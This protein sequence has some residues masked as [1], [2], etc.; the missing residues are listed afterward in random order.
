[1][2]FFRKTIWNSR[3]CPLS[4]LNKVSKWRHCI[5][6]VTAVVK[7]SKT[8]GDVLA[9]LL[10]TTKEADPTNITV[11]QQSIQNLLRSMTIFWERVLLWKTHLGY[12]QQ[13][14]A[15]LKYIYFNTI[16]KKKVAVEVAA[17]S[18]THRSAEEQERWATWENSWVLSAQTCTAN[19]WRLN[20]SNYTPV[21]SAH[22]Y[23]KVLLFCCRTLWRRYFYTDQC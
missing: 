3:R 11:T 1:M 23:S 6:V 13:Q 22:T 17:S 15:D 19:T 16:Q 12:E 18:K 7:I 20:A 2:H 9:N 10:T 8:W 4:V 14:E 21:S 5:L